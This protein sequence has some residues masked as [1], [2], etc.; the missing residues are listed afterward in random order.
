MSWLDDLIGPVVAYE[1]GVEQTT[2]AKW[3]FIGA[4]IS[5]NTATDSLDITVGSSAG[6]SHTLYVDKGGNDTTAIRGAIGFPYLTIQAALDD[7]QSGD[8]V[9]VGPGTFTEKITFPELAAISLIGSGSERTFIRWTADDE[10]LL[11]APA[12]TAIQN[13]T[14]ARLSIWSDGGGAASFTI[15]GTQLATKGIFVSGSLRMFDVYARTDSGLGASIRCAGTVRLD[16]VDTDALSVLE[17]DDALVQD[18]ACDATTARWDATGTVPAGV[19]GLHSNRFRNCTMSSLA[20]QGVA[21]VDA[22]ECL[23]TS[24]TTCTFTEDGAEY[25]KLRSNSVHHGAVIVGAA[26][27]AAVSSADLRGASMTALTATSSA[28]ALRVTVEA[29]GATVSGAVTA[30]TLCDIDIR[31]GTYGSLAAAGSGTVE[32]STHRQTVALINGD[33]DITFAVPFTTANYSIAYERTVAANDVITP[34][35]QKRNTGFRATAVAIDA[36]ASCIIIHD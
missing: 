12:S 36:A 21:Q 29:R 11:I 2:R 28:G 5:D 15:K 20:P 13:A 8:I 6:E 1:D 9:Q 24:T 32:R 19:T 25:G 34:A 33:T 30:N 10:T 4:A 18:S 7:A 23:V 26:S 17:V 16:H 3:N 22:W 31:G 14:I 27:V 35:A